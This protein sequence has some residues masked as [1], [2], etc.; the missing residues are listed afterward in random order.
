[1]GIQTF[2]RFVPEAVVRNIIKGQDLQLRSLKSQ[3]IAA[4]LGGDFGEELSKQCSFCGLN[5]GWC[6]WVCCQAPCDKESHSAA[7]ISLKLF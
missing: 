5:T 4:L 2:A 7:K 3:V 1:M 6:R